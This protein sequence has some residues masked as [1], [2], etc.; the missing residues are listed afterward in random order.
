M[1]NALFTYILCTVIYYF[2]CSSFYNSKN[3]LWLLSSIINLIYAMY[4]SKCVGSKLKIFAYPSVDFNSEQVRF[5]C[6]QN[7]VWIPEDVWTGCFM[8][9]WG[10]CNSR[11]PGPFCPRHTVSS[12]SLLQRKVF[13][14]Y[15]TKVN[16]N[17]YYLE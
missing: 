16:W 12:C 9:E 8:H 5:K 7:V 1:D 10:I 3:K 14:Q 17:M 4:V 15:I 2:T 13:W 11:A 6:I